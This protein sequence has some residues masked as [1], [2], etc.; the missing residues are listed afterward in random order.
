MNL[1]PIILLCFLSAN[2]CT[3]KENLKRPIKQGLVVMKT[4]FYDSSGT[5]KFV[6]TLKIWYKD[7][8]AIQEIHRINLSNNSSKTPPQV[9]YSVILYR[10]MDLKNKALYDYKTFS[11]SAVMQNKASLPDSGMRDYGWSFYSEVLRRI[12][13]TPE[14]LSDTILGNVTYRRTRFHFTHDDPKKSFIVGYFRCDGVNEMFSLEKSYSHKI[15]CVMTKFSEF[16]VDQINPFA[17][18]EVEF[19][20]DSLNDRELGVFQAWGTNAKQNP[21]IK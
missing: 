5:V 13:G 21:I 11:D 4:V 2:A 6:D 18:I 9:T 20:S 3:S 16:G 1:S 8:V 7:S 15:G 12:Q 10:Y 14:P 17:T 19:I